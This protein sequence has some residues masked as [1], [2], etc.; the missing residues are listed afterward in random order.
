MRIAVIG[1]VHETNSF[2]LEQIDTP[3]APILLG[4]EVLAAAHPKS[5][6]GG[7]MEVTAE[8]PDVEL[9][10]IVS[11]DLFAYRGGLLHAS[12]FEY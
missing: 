4:A 6:I 11:L 5:Y 3:D 12:V 8:R 2:S 10:P 9:V 7:F 1:L